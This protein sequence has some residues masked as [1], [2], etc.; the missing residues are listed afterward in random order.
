M[1]PKE[2]ESQITKWR[3]LGLEPHAIPITHPDGVCYVVFR[4]LTKL[5]FMVEKGRTLSDNPT[6]ALN[7]EIYQN[8]IELCVLY[9]NPLPDYLPAAADNIIYNAILEA[10]GWESTEK[11]VA[12]VNKQREEASTLD[13]FIKAKILSVFTN[14]DPNKFNTMRL[15]D[16]IQLA[17]LAENISGVPIDFEPWLDP[18]GYNARLE[19]EKKRQ[20]RDSVAAHENATAALMKDPEYRKRM[21]GRATRLG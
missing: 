2:I 4:T 21:M 3:T 1:F 18:E 19:K 17:I 12:E 7:P 11:L 20:Q 8:L 16:I 9:P 13:Y 5:E 6:G 15:P 14:L 10:S